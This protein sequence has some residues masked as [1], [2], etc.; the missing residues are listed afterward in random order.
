M[1]D[2]THYLDKTPQLTRQKVLNR[3]VWV[4]SVIVFLL[5]SAMRSPYKIPLPEGLSFSFLPPIHALINTGT[6]ICLIAALFAVKK[7]EITRHKR[8]MTG[9]FAFSVAFFICYVT[10]HFTTEETRYGGEGFLRGLYFFVLAS[11]ILTA[12]I[13]LPFILLTFVAA[14]TNDFP[15]HRRLARK[16]YPLWLY[17]AVTGPI[18]YLMLMPYY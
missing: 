14:W 8:L 4:V 2:L 7:G 17:A 16:V 12:A 1:P 9:A 15:R 3:G 18:C 11:H 6:S 5:V 10:Y 13:S